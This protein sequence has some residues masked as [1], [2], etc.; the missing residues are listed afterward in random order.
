[1]NDADAQHELCLVQNNSSYLNTVCTFKP[2]L[3]KITRNAI[4]LNLP[5][6]NVKADLPEVAD[7][8][9]SKQLQI[10]KIHPSYR[11]PLYHCTLALRYV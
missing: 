5:S 7:R 3:L 11:D 9:V 4:H 8:Y 1:M 10:P 6:M 2:D